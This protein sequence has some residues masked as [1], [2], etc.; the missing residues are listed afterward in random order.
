MFAAATGNEDQS[1]TAQDRTHR[2][3]TQQLTGWAAV[4][5]TLTDFDQQ[6]VSGYKEDI[7]SLLTFVSAPS[8]SS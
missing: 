1:R 5:K 4:E 8:S 6:E 2:W 3:Q 7:D